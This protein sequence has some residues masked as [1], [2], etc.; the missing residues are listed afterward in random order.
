MVWKSHSSERQES[1]TIMILDSGIKLESPA[2]ALG[3]GSSTSVGLSFLI[4]KLE[5]IIPL[6]QVVCVMCWGSSLA[7]SKQWMNG[8]DFFIIRRKGEGKRS[9]I[10]WGPPLSEALYF[11]LR[12]YIAFITCT[13]STSWELS[14][15]MKSPKLG[16]T[17]RLTKDREQ[18]SDSGITG[19]QVCVSK[20]HALSTHSPWRSQHINSNSTSW[21]TRE[22]EQNVGHKLQWL[23]SALNWLQKNVFNLW[24]DKFSFKYGVYPIF[25]TKTAQS[26]WNFTKIYC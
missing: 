10:H 22:A 8:G 11:I 2:P 15:Q 18:I 26:P 13:D 4:C 19:S 16:M 9:H 6:S 7:H 3:Q 12:F 17:K 20:G 1:T 25:N 24:R 23:I 21:Y 14:L 5:L